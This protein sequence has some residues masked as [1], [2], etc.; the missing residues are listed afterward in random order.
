MAVVVPAFLSFKMVP[1][2]VLGSPSG[3]VGLASIASVKVAVTLT[4]GAIIVALLAGLVLST[5]GGVVSAGMSAQSGSVEPPS[6]VSLLSAVC[7]VVC[8][9]AAR[10][11]TSLPAS[12]ITPLCW[13]VVNEAV[14]LGGGRGVSAAIA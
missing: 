4:P 10:G 5:L 13:L 11:S 12:P 1:V 2:I 6:V 8:A 14:S 7:E 9:L 3:G